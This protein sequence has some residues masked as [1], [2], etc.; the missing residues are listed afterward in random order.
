M[1][2]EEQERVG[3]GEVLSLIQ[4]VVLPQAGIDSLTVSGNEM[5]LNMT[6]STLQE[7]NLLVQKLEADP[8]VDFCNVTTAESNEYN[9]RQD[10]YAEN[11]VVTA[12]VIAYLVTET[13]AAG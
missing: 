13:E 7:I 4:R 1:T 2:K 5:T 3:R 11:G 10:L 8:L 9:S 12:K 6:G